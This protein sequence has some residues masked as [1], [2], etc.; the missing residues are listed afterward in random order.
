[1]TNMYPIGQIQN[2]PTCS[3]LPCLKSQAVGRMLSFITS[4]KVGLYNYVDKNNNQMCDSSNR[5]SSDMDFVLIKA[6]LDPTVP[7][8]KR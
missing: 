5:K 7:S 3:C 4:R 2:L 6:P 8:L 1:M